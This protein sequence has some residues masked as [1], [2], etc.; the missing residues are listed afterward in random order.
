MKAIQSTPT[1][2]RNFSVVIFNLFLLL[3]SGWNFIEVK[4]TI[5][6][7]NIFLF[8]S[9]ASDCV[10]GDD[11]AAAESATSFLLK[12]LQYTISTPLSNRIL[13]NLVT[14][15]SKFASTCSKENAV[16]YLRYLALISQF[17]GEGNDHFALSRECGAVDELF[18]VCKGLPPSSHQ[19]SSVFYVV[20][21]L[22]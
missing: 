7:E 12:L 6:F 16:K 17:C 10:D 2:Q 11:I 5:P 14:S 21:Y 19:V 1:K 9:I 15:S 20:V 8:S 18:R 13:T 22:F 4:S 3:E